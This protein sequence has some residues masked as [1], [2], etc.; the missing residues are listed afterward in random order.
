MVRHV[1]KT[2]LSRHLLDMK[3]MKKSKEKAEK[4]AEEEEHRSLFDSDVM[5]SI[6]KEGSMYVCEESYVPCINQHLARLSFKGRNPEIERLMR[7]N[8]L[9]NPQHP[10]MTGISDE[11]MAERYSTLVGTMAKKFNKKKRRSSPESPSG[12]SNRKAP[13]MTEK[14]QKPSEDD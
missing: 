6:K 13:R 5:D 2:K 7:E 3:F 14:F 12:N 8:E 9:K 10:K 4:D 11:D 1:A